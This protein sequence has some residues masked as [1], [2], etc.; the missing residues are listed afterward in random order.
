MA[1]NE[2]FGNGICEKGKPIMWESVCPICKLTDRSSPFY[3]DLC[4]NFIKHGEAMSCVD[5]PPRKISGRIRHVH[6]ECLLK[7]Y[8]KEKREGNGD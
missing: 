4:S 2:L 5:L 7:M 6:T 3:C 1:V 8:G